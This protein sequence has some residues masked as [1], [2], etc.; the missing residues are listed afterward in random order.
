MRPPPAAY[1]RVHACSIWWQ[2]IPYF[3]LGV[4]EV[5]TNVGC[6]ELFYTQ[7]SE[8]MRS[9]GA[10]IYLL[11]VAVGMYLSSALNVAVAAATAKDLWIADNPLYGHYDWWGMCALM[12]TGSETCCCSL[13]LLARDPDIT[14]PQIPVPQVLLAQRCHLGCRS[15]AVRRRGQELHRKAA[16]KAPGHTSRG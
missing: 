8:G 11:S 9:L 6:M 5:F 14:S 7:M 16:R 1:V 4:S 15:A 12:H 3:L 10:S 13:C 2:V